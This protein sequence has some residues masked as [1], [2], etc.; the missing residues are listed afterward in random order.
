VHV[1]PIPGCG[2]CFKR[3]EH[4]KRHVRGIHT[5]EKVGLRC[6]IRIQIVTNTELNVASHSLIIA[7]TMVAGKA[8]QDGITWDYTIPVSP[9]MKPSRAAMLTTLFY[10]GSQDVKQEML[11]I[12]CLGRQ[13]GLIRRSLCLP[14]AY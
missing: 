13:R 12:A 4:V 7:C 5:L 6:W 1:C 11:A 3:R 8:S 14:Y 10:R 2:A 9:T